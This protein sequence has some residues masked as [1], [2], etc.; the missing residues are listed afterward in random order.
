MSD[1]T[2]ALVAEKA[3]LVDAIDLGGLSVIGIMQAHDG[4]AVLLRSSRGRIA[5]LQ[6]GERAFG[7]TVAAIGEAEVILSDRTGM[8]HRLGVPGA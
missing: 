7:M 5:R 6:T 8:Q 1:Q 3:T 2:S 4:P